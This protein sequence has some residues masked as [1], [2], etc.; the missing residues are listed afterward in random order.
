MIEITK[1]N[2]DTWN[3]I[4]YTWILHGLLEDDRIPLEH[5]PNGVVSKYGRCMTIAG[6]LANQVTK[7]QKEELKKVNILRIG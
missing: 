5:Y 3:T 2:V 4:I 7:Q 6:R 1:N